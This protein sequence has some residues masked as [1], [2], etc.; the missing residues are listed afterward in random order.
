MVGSSSISYATIKPDLQNMD[1]V[2]EHVLQILRV[3]PT[4]WIAEVRHHKNELIES[5]YL[6]VTDRQKVS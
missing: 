6:T 4:D 1:L 5:F 3:N 2:A